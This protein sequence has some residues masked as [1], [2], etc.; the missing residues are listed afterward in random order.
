M[1]GLVLHHLSFF[2][3]FRPQQTKPSFSA[4]PT[5]QT[6]NQTARLVRH[7]TRPS[8]ECHSMERQTSPPNQPLPDQTATAKPGQTES[9]HNQPCLLSF[10]SALHTQSTEMVQVRCF[11]CGLGQ[12]GYIELWMNLTKHTFHTPSA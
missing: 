11:P 5:Y 6:I 10:K 9:D 1:T 2:L 12:G 4:R 7:W 8:D 3:I